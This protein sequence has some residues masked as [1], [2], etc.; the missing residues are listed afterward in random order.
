MREPAMSELVKDRVQ[1]AAQ[2]LGT[3]DP[4]P[5]VGKLID[6]SFPL[7]V[8]DNRYAENHLLPGAAGFE[9]SFSE[10]EP[11][12]LRFTIEPLG[13][14]SSPGSRRDETTR[15]M[16][17]LAGQVFGAD[18]LRWF[19]SRS[20]EWRGHNGVTQLHFGA[21][22]GTAYDGDGLQA[23]KVYYELTPAQMESL[24]PTL[25]EIARI[26]AQTI[27]RL[28]PIF[29]TITCRR[30][31]GAQRLTFFH[32]GSLRLAELAPLLEQLGLGHRLP[33][34][35]QIVGLALGGRFELPEGT[36][37]LGLGDAGDGPELKLEVMLG[38]LPDL[39]R[40]FLD[41][42]AL[43][44][45]E[46]PRQLRALG[47]WMQ[48]FTPRDHDTPGDFSVMSVRVTRSTPARVSLYLRPVEFELRRIVTSERNR[49]MPQTV[50]V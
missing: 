20:E 16:R 12:A 7:E 50:G 13:P 27:P 11:R 37:L 44:L 29:T 8:G 25:A 31:A 34:L 48:A 45:A 9:P 10:T 32:R 33:S 35:M 36:V 4:L 28:V 41:L 6:A 15:V 38:M 42:L 17:S 3:S 26:A 18:A 49:P 19:D 47:Q 46:R 40:S 1:T 21:W 5:Y 43:G 24:P 39:P 30:Q 22:L 2:V 14:Q 23:S